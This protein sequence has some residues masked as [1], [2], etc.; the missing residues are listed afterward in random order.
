MRILKKIILF[1][2]SKIGIRYA[3]SELVIRVNKMKQIK[4]LI[5]G[6]SPVVIDGGAHK[7]DFIQLINRQFSSPKIY[8]Y[9]PIPLL[10]EEL[11]TKFCQTSLEIREVALG[12]NKSQIELNLTHLLPA[13]S[14][15]EAGEF[16]EKYHASGLD[17][18]EKITIT[19]VRLDEELNGE[20]DILK[21]DLQG[22]ELE[23]LKGAEKILDSVKLVLIE[24]E[25]IPMY[26]NQPLFSDID[27]FL[28][29]HSFRL[30]NFYELYTHA[31]GQLTSGDAI[32]LN[33]KFFN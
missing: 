9:E 33:S 21:L 7:G 15:L 5:R 32:Y 19:Q 25:F 8:A 17:S 29:Q 16:A 3:P 27:L 30:L 14:I 26:K 28:R 31:D 6:E 1:A 13:S 11:R 20:V 23:A 12:A 2:F 4:S 18:A 22:Y 10:A 24:V